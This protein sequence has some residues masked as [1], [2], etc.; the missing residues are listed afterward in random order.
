MKEKKRKKYFLK[1]DE[2]SQVIWFYFHNYDNIIFEVLH[3]IL[4]LSI[5]VSTYFPKKLSYSLIKETYT[6]IKTVY[7]ELQGIF[8]YQLT[9]YL[10]Q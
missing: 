10:S 6:S 1:L 9:T 2:K 8:D 3:T 7:I 5:I 4:Y